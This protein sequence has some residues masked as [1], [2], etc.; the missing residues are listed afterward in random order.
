MAVSRLASGVLAH[1]VV[2][3]ADGVQI[4]VVETGDP[5]G[6]PIVFV[7]GIS[8]SWRSWAGQ[9]GDPGLAARYRL[10]ALD[11]RGH[12]ESAGAYGALDP[13][14]RPLGL[15]AGERYDDG[16]MEGAS[17]LWAHDLDAAI[18]ALGLADAVLVG[19]SYG[20][21]VVQGYLL[22][23]GGLGA[24][25]QAVL[26]ATVPVIMSPGSPGS[27]R[28]FAV[29]EEALGALLQVLPVDP[30]ADPPRPNDHGT[31]ARGLAEFNDR[32]LADETGR[33]DSPAEL[34]YAAS[35]ASLL[36]PPEVRLAI[37]SRAFDYRP[38][39]AGLPEGERAR[40]CAVTP[41]GDRV[42]RAEML[43]RFWD[44]A[45]VANTRVAAE[46]HAFMLRNPEGFNALLANLAG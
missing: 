7:H 6:R 22:T 42:F 35:A 12:G 33:G 9:L 17:R 32:C 4:H 39:L 26:F 36:S 18:G 40:V 20:G 25:G 21:A 15:L 10:V 16:T 27:E 13:G 24:A 8:Q 30:S 29:R 23:H 34:V 3:T 5:A 19:W 2:T 14:G 46:G 28:D 11:L 45:R 38:F 37:L 44:E 41:Q 1:R 31:I 43:N